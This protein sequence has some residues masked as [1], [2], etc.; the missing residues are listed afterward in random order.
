MAHWAV[1]LTY[2]PAG[3]YTDPCSLPTPCGVNGKERLLAIDPVRPARA[4]TSQSPSVEETWNRRKPRYR[5][6]RLSVSAGVIRHGGNLG[7]GQ[8]D[9]CGSDIGVQV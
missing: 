3:V 6:V 9:A 2:S 4:G 5:P 1:V 8:L 7:H